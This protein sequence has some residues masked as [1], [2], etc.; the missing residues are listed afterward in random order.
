MARKR[1]KITEQTSTVSGVVADVASELEELAQEM[2]DWADNMEESFSHTDK[3][4]QVSDVADT[5]E[6]VDLDIEVPRI[7]EDLTVKY[8][9]HSP[10]GRKGASRSMR[11]DNFVM[12]LEAAQ[13]IAQLELDSGVWEEDSDQPD[14][15]EEFI[16]A[17]DDIIGE[18]QGVDFPGAFG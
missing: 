16:Q 5:L 8:M 12:A 15:I 14:E 6:Y 13:G 9:I 1:F 11:R 10:Y 17:L 4:Q 2:R 3:F 7:V 18:L